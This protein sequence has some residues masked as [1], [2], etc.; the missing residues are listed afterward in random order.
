MVESD[1]AEVRRAADGATKTRM[2][3]SDD[4]RARNRAPSRTSGHVDRQPS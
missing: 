2:I 3:H 4:D 1:I